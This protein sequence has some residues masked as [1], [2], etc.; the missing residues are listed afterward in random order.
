MADYAKR[1][2]IAGAVTLGCRGDLAVPE[3]DR[4]GAGFG[5]SVGRPHP[6]VAA[7]TDAWCMQSGQIGRSQRWQITPARRSGWR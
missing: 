2:E 4:V 6:V 7:G 3:C 1:R 5:R